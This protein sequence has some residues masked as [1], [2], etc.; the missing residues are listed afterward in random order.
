MMKKKLLAFLS[1]LACMAGCIPTAAYA[2]SPW[3]ESVL[4]RVLEAD[5][6]GMTLELLG[7]SLY[8]LSVCGADMEELWKTQEIPKPNDIVKLSKPAFVAEIYPGCL[9]YSEES[10]LVFENLGN[11][12]DICKKLPLTVTEEN[13]YSYKLTD[14]AGNLYT[15]LD[16]D[17]FL[18]EA[19]EGTVVN[20]LVYGEYAMLP[21]PTGR[22]STF[23]VV[24]MDNKDA[25]EHYVLQ[26]PDCETFYVSAEVLSEYL[27][28]ERTLVCGDILN[29]YTKT[30]GTSTEGTGSLGFHHEG[31]GNEAVYAGSLYDEPETME[32]T[33]TEK[34]QTLRYTK[35]EK[36]GESY[37]YLVDYLKFADGIWTDVKRS[38]IQP[39]EVDMLSLHEGDKVTMLTYR[40][41]PVLP[42]SVNP[43]GDM[44]GSGSLDILDV[45][46]ANRHILGAEEL[47]AAKNLPGSLGQSDFNGNGR[48]DADDS[49]GMLKRIV[50]LEA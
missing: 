46:I 19:T 11:A 50:G 39:C 9:H 25:P 8:T 5:E 31:T 21:E 26:N 22:F 17:L 49:L 36:D 45:I 34:R 30:Y 18:I 47:P 24:G 13:G 7:D 10:P 48:I 27:T 20:C 41:K 2:V 4:Y 12:K 38:Y 32:F 35:L 6:K 29:I 40:G 15:Y 14:D 44:D 37:Q 3:D 1:A 16:N 42:Y 43:L 33:V 28:E 23:F